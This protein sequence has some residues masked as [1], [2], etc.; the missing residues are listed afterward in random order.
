MVLY[1]LKIENNTSLINNTYLSKDNCN[2]FRGLFA[3]I[4]IIHHIAKSVSSGIILKPFTQ[5]GYLIVA[6]FFFYS[7][8]GLMKKH[9]V[10]VHGMYENNA[11]LI[12]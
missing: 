6:V 12:S 5:V 9:I 11:Q 10:V 1:G 8:Y 3:L 2:S 4:I 7:G